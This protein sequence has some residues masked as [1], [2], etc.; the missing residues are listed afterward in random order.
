MDIVQRSKDRN[1]WISPGVFGL[2][3]F[4]SSRYGHTTPWGDLMDC[5]GCRHLYQVQWGR[6]YRIACLEGIHIPREWERPIDGERLALLLGFGMGRVF[7]KPAER[8]RKYV[9]NE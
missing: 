4:S 7:D 3:S 1:P 2:K 8:C 9:R 5:H 6:R